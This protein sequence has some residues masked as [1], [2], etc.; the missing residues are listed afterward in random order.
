MGRKRIRKSG[1]IHGSGEVNLGRHWTLDQ[2][3][4]LYSLLCHLRKPRVHM[5]LHARRCHVVREV[6][7][8][9]AGSKEVHEN[10]TASV[11]K[12]LRRKGLG[13]VKETVFT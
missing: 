7:I 9:G 13:E 3:I 5:R 8:V 2:A 11:V 1:I 4:C 10:Q 6:I 12:N